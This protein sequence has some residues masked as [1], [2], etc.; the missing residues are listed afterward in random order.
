MI[1]EVLRKSPRREGDAHT[2]QAAH[3]R[4]QTST[5]NKHQKHW[6]LTSLPAILAEAV[7]LGLR[8]YLSPPFLV[9]CS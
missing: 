4:R 3:A 5:A 6:A 7:G 8:F 9:L 2:V 1:S